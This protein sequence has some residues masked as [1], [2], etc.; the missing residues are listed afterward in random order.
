VEAAAAAAAAA[1]A[2]GRGV[3]VPLDEDDPVGHEPG[4]LVAEATM[5]TG[6]V[7]WFDNKKGY[8]FIENEEGED[9]FVHYSNIL[10]EGFRTLKHGTEVQFRPV[11]SERG[12]KAEEVAVLSEESLD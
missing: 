5:A 6:R 2:E 12:W 9:V 4:R 8:G 10:S 3:P 7:K 1:A 11:P